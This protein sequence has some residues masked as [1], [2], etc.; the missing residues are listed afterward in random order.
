MFLGESENKGS[1]EGGEKDLIGGNTWK[2][3]EEI[4]F[5]TFMRVPN[6][7]V[8]V[9]LLRNHGVVCCGETI[10]EAWYNTYHTVLAC[11]TQVTPTTNHRR[12]YAYPSTLAPIEPIIVISQPLTTSDPPHHSPL[13]H[14]TSSLP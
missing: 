7:C 13:S 11:E 1:H 9:M 10:E 5:K 6:V 14:L 2:E 4:L 8:Q 3:E 12:S